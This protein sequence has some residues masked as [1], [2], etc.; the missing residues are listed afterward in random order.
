MTGDAF[1]TWRKRP[2]SVTWKSWGLSALRRDSR[3]EPGS[4]TTASIS[5]TRTFS[6]NLSGGAG[7]ACPAWPVGEAA[8]GAAGREGGGAA[9]VATGQALKASRAARAA[10]VLIVLLVLLVLVE[11]ACRERPPRGLPG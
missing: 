11:A 1:T 7:D 5:R 9:A 8:R 4:S 2:S 6:S 10:V 3:S